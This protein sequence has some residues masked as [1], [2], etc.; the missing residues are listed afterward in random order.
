MARIKKKRMNFVID[1]TPLVDITFLLLTFLM[2]T[3]KFKSEAESEQE[4]TITR[5]L[6][7]PDTTKLPEKDIAI[8]NVAI[9]DKNTK[10]TSYYYGLTNTKDWQQV[11]SYMPEI[12]EDMKSKSLIKVDTTMLGRFIKYTLAVNNAT[13][14][15]LDA[16][17]RVRFKYI[18]DVMNTL[19][20]NK[21]FTFNFVTEKR[22]GEKEEKKKE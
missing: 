11:L 16:D 15:A 20:K 6:A 2:F 4:F 14:F 3:A 12:P 5:P 17:K 22:K 21:A 19:R 18:E 1:M 13:T 10:D 7:S 8:I 9:D